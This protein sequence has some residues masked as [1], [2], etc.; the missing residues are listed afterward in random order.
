MIDLQWKKVRIGEGDEILTAIQQEESDE[1]ARLAKGKDVLEIGSAHGYSAIVMALA[2][3][4]VTAVDSHIGDT[5]LGDTYSS[6]RRNAQTYGVLDGIEM[7]SEQDTVALPVL[8]EDGRKFGLIFVDAG[9]DYKE[10]LFDL[11]WTLKLLNHGGTIA[12]HDYDHANYPGKRQ[13]CDEMFPQGPDKLV[14]S[15]FVISPNQT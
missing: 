5:W 6:M 4:R 3:G 8:W 13:A 1:L 15:L 10:V 7:I 11:K 12:V 2:G 9:G 14:V